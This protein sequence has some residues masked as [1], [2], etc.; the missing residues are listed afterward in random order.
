MTFGLHHLDWSSPAPE[1]NLACD[2][3]LLDRCEADSG[4]PVLRFWEA[5]GLFAVVGYANHVATEVDV[6]A[7][8][9]AGVPILRRCS[10]GGAVL[11][12]PG[13][14][15]Y[16][17]VLPL[18]LDP[19]LASISETNRFV[20]DRHRSAVSELTG[21]P[22][23]VRGH[24]DLAVGRLKFSGNSQRRKRKAVLFHGTFLLSFDLAAME[25]FLRFPS[26]QP[27][28]RE[29]RTHMEFATNLDLPV[30]A[31]KD[32]LLRCWNATQPLSDVPT[33]EIDTLV[34]NR[35]SQ[36]SWNLRA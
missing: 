21:R 26:K 20:M 17:L 28:Y 25:Q 24:T 23:E 1:A 4:P 10:G 36:D 22:V 13:C 33:K 6:N 3:A 32:A 18:G 7:C 35:Y 11:Q 15:N 12:G 30:A 8:R 2:E 29:G 27:D 9:D 5:P 34:R 16:G 14:L 19:A 31:V